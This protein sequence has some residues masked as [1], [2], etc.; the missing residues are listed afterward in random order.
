MRTFSSWLLLAVF[1]FTLFLPVPQGAA[2]GAGIK[3]NNLVMTGPVS[4]PSSGCAAGQ[5]LNFRAEFDLT[6]QLASGPN[7]QV[8]AYAPNTDWVLAGSWQLNPTGLVSAAAYTPGESSGVCSANLPSGYALIGS[9]YA[10]LPLS[11]FADQLTFALRINPVATST[12]TLLVRIYQAASDGTTWTQS[13]QLVRTLDVYPASS[14]AYVGNDSAA[15][16]GYAP[17]YVNSGD[18]LA[19]GLGTGLKD[20]IDAQSAPA[21]ITILG[22]YTIKSNTVLLD[23]AHTL[24]GVNNASLTYAG[25]LCSQPMLRITAGATVQNLAVNGGTCAAARRDLLSLESSAPIS[26]LSND[27]TFGK[28]AISVGAAHNGSVLV[29]FNYI[30]SNTGYGI[31]WK[32]AA[33]SGTLF[34][35]GNN[36]FGNR[37]GFQVECNNRGQVDHNFWGSGILPSSAVSNCSVSNGRRLGAAIQLNDSAPGVNAQRITVTDAKTGYF[38][39]AISFRHDPDSPNFDLYVVNHGAGSTSNIPFLG[40]GANA[41]TACS[42]FWDV[43]LADGAAAPATLTISLKYDL[44]TAC[45]NQ[46]ESAAYCA[47]SDPALFPLMW[48]DPSANI[49]AGWDN[50]GAPPQ[51]S[52]AGGVS[53]QTTTCLVDSDEIELALDS[54]GRPNLANDLSFTPLVVGLPYSSVNITQFTA[55]VVGQATQIDWQTSSENNIGGFYV[56]RSLNNPA[57]PYARTST[58]IAAKGSSTIG[59]IY[60]YQDTNLALGST[61]YYKLEVLDSGAQTVEFIGPA[62]ATLATATPTITPTPSRTLTPTITSTLSATYTFTPSRTATLLPTRTRTFVPVRTNTRTLVPSF[63][64]TA[65]YLFRTSTNTPTRPANLGT[66]T[67]TPTRGT[68]GTSTPTLAG[69]PVTGTPQTTDSGYPVQFTPT[70][71]TLAV[72]TTPEFT[73]TLTPAS[74]TVTAQVRAQTLT[75][76]APTATSPAIPAPD[77]GGSTSLVVLILLILAALAVGGGLAWRYLR[78][79]APP[80]PPPSDE[81]EEDQVS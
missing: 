81:D 73:A 80:P 20:A 56:V 46:V 74:L 21:V 23:K 39:Q 64:P 14:T 47:Q 59:A 19:D 75:A 29:R 16:E 13:A 77:S 79:N 41:L 55:A 51:G 30:G 67:L 25:S 78:R 26:I 71:A 53:G 34:A 50:T 28:D 62:T 40:S 3:T 70:A 22:N 57:G 61:Y 12:G 18:D 6:P 37:S 42:S 4:C 63:T 17:C 60:N 68:P 33:S 31:N 24:Q 69:Y 65:T 76:L 58:Y 52:G 45:L 38:N 8:C 9:G 35:V 44:N 54:S 27:L 72:T 48:Y 49:T 66:A 36:I 10:T 5:R 43:F 11:A 2:Q 15:C 1:L 32:N 7:T